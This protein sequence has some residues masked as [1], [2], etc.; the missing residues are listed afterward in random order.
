MFEFIL[1]ILSCM[2][3]YTNFII[4]KFIILLIANLTLLMRC[5]F[6]LIKLVKLIIIILNLLKI[7]IKTIFIL[8]IIILNLLINYCNLFNYY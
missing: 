7:L 3:I 5:K 6:A 4:I 1:R 8:I 2:L